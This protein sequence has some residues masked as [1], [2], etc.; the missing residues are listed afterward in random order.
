M[1]PT[2]STSDERS[3]SLPADFKMSA[4]CQQRTHAL[5]QTAALSDHLVGARTHSHPLLIQQLRQ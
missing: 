4:P 3:H 5:Q 2:L 1:D